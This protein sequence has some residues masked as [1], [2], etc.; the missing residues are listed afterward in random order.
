[1]AVSVIA[2]YMAG[3]R[4]LPRNVR[5]FNDILPNQE[6]S[7]AYLMACQHVQ[8][9]RRPGIIGTVVKCKRQLPRTSWLTDKSPPKELRARRHGVVT[10]TGQTGQTYTR[11]PSQH[12]AGIV[13]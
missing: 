13:N 7:G 11:Q 10:S 9:S 12:R 1:M 4:N 5:A 8:K 2:D 6:E 3:S